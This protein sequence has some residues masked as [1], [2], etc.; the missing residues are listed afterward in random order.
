MD[1]VFE[2]VSFAYESFRRTKR[3]SP[4]EKDLSDSAFVLRDL[5]FAL[6][7]TQGVAIL[8]RSGSGKS[9]LL[10]LFT[11]LTKPTQG[12]IRIDGQ[13]IHSGKLSLPLLRQRLGVVFQ[14][15]ESQ[16]FEL[17]VYDD[18]AYGPRNL[19]LAETVVQQRVHEALNAVG[20]P[21]TDFARVD[22]MHLSQG[23]KRRAAIAGTLAMQPAMLILD[24]PTAGLDADGRE[25][26][27]AALHG[28]RSRGMG[29]LLISHDT[30]LA[31]QFSQRAL[32]LDAS[33]MIYDGELSELF[34][35]SSVALRYGLEVPRAMR[36]AKRLSDYGI[37]SDL[38][39]RLLTD[40]I[41]LNH[42]GEVDKNP[43]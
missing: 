42:S 17:S 20:L 6:A 26:L 28:C 36:L 34:R 33:R 8:G 4:P 15:P 22:P 24:E 13:N 11:G 3:A 41:V 23:E 43:S 31:V 38:A 5:S 29:L 32:V 16:L 19:R 1:I 25:R 12:V 27:I 39:Q 37:S 9:T 2:H 35:D 30:G 18:V 21:P 14:F 40:E 10:N 7:S